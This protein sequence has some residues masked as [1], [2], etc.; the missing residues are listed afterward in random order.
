M[1][2]TGLDRITALVTDEEASNDELEVFR[3]AGIR[4]IRAEVTPEDRAQQDT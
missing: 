4:V 2:V 3:S 1:I